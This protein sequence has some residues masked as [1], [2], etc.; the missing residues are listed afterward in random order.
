MYVLKVCN[1]AHKVAYLLFK[2]I[3]FNRSF[4]SVP[5]AQPLLRS[6]EELPNSPLV[7]TV[8]QGTALEALFMVRIKNINQP[9]HQVK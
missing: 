6:L 2:F 5:K 9:F 4:I 8:R 3:E 1:T 7:W